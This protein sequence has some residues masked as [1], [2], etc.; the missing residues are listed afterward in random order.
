M[1]KNG[2]NNTKSGIFEHG[3]LYFAEWC[4]KT[5]NFEHEETFFA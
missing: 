4:A 3:G 2:K 1:E 5:G